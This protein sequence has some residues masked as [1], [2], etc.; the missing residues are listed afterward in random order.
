MDLVRRNVI[1]AGHARQQFTS[2]RLVPDEEHHNNIVSH[3]TSLI[4][5]YILLF[6]K[7]RT[8]PR[9]KR[10]SKSRTALLEGI[11]TTLEAAECTRYARHGERAPTIFWF[12]PTVGFAP[13]LDGGGGG[14]GVEHG[15]R[16]EPRPCAYQGAC[17]CTTT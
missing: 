9:P 7:Y 6:F 14:G 8:G 2:V 1:D 17:V 3:T 11:W 10:R 13:E 16:T 4:Y 12:L 5:N 15:N